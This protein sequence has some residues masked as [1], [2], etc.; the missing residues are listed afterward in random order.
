MGLLC[1]AGSTSGSSDSTPPQE[2]LPT[3][4][5]QC[6]MWNVWI[7]PVT[8]ELRAAAPSSAAPNQRLPLCWILRATQEAA[9]R[10]WLPPLAVW[11]VFRTS[12]TKACPKKD[13]H[14]ESYTG[15]TGVQGSN[16]REDNQ[17]INTHKMY[18]HVIIQTLPV[19][20]HC[21][22]SA[23]MFAY[24]SG[25]CELGGGGGTR[26]GPC[27]DHDSQPIKSSLFSRHRPAAA[28]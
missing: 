6:S 26:V 11:N 4:G 16:P 25:Q 24:L 28:L 19:S 27:A 1:L 14:R 20:V 2:S 23:A 17:P 7:H 22:L 12:S 8:Q 10:S 15:A 9:V 13:T 18:L 3:E 5:P 21:K